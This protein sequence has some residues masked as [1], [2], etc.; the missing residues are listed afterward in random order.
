L[1]RALRALNKDLSTAHV[2]DS[3]ARLSSAEPN[4][5]VAVGGHRPLPVGAPSG[6]GVFTS[7]LISAIFSWGSPGCC[8]TV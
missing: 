6:R 7:G 5:L 3:L 2:A 8:L 1:N 4:D